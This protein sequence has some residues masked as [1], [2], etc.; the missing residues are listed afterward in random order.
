[1]FHILGIIASTDFHIFQRGRYTTKQFK[2]SAGFCCETT[3]CEVAYYLV[4]LVE[5]TKRPA[6]C[7]VHI[8]RFCE[9]NP[10]V[11]VFI[12]LGVPVINGLIAMVGQARRVKSILIID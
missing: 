7:V 9:G 2:E 12:N 8:P 5:K 1:M 11:D 4:F 3:F 10:L 6:F